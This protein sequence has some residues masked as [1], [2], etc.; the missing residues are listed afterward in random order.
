MTVAEKISEE[1]IKMPEGNTFKYQEL[2]IG[3]DEYTAATKAIERLIK[4]GIIKRASTGLFYKPQ[5][6]IFGFLNPDEQDLLRPYLFEGKKRI[7]YITGGALYNRLGLT[8]Q[9]PR[10]IKIALKQLLARSRYLLFKHPTKW[11]ES[12]KHRAALLFLGFPLLKKAHDLGIALGDIFNK[13]KDKKV[14][15]TRLGLW[16]NQVDASGIASFE[17]VARSIAA[18]HPYI[19]HYFDNKSTNAS[20][21]FFNAKLKAFRS[22][23]RGVRD[24]Q[25]FLYRVM[26]LYA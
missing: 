2:N 7:A 10:N 17:S 21:E 1:I 23:F 19:L 9:V 22:I 14:A 8:T 16:H 24:T 18:H 6:T 11:T 20:A 26:K 3:R 4:K 5:K 13:C 12:Q 25:F 15:F